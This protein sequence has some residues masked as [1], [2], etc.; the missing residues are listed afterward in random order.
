M[1]KTR[2]LLDFRIDWGYIYLYSRRHYHPQYIWDGELT[3]KDG[4]ILESY[5]L[6]Y[7]LAWYMPGLCPNE[8]KLP[9]PRW[10]SRTKRHIA[11]VRFV[12]EVTEDT[13]FTLSTQSGTFF[14]T[15]QQIQQDGRITFTV[16]PK[17][18]Q[19]QVIVTRTGY[20]W[21]RP[22]CP[23]GETRFMEADLP[24]PQHQWSRTPLAYLEPGKTV[25]VELSVPQ[26][27]ADYPE[28]LMHM[29]AMAVPAYALPEWPVKD[30][31]PM[32]LSCDGETILS[33]RYFFNHHDGQLQI[34]EDVWQR[35]SVSP[36]KHVI[37]LKNLHPELCLGI[38]RIGFTQR[39]FCHGQVSL[40]QWALVNE[41]VHGAVFAAWTDTI[42]VEG[43]GLQYQLACTPGWNE[44][45]ICPE[46]PG[47]LTLSTKN[48]SDS[49]EVYPIEE[50]AVPVKVGADMTQI[51]HDDTGTMDWLLE[52][53]HRTRLGNYVIFRSFTGPVADEL[54]YRWGDYCRRHGIY[55]AACT[56][57]SSGAFSKGAGEYQ[58]ACGIH[59]YTGLVYARDP[60]EP[61]LSQDMKQAAEKFQKY[62]RKEISAVR[63]SCPTVAF[64]DGSGGSRH[65]FIAGADF[66]RAETMVGHTMTL[67]SQA[68]P[69]AEA[70]GNGG[71]GVHIA[72]QH[73]RQPYMSTHLGEYFLCLMQPWIMGAELIY[74][75][76]CLFGMWSEERMT[77]DDL[78]VKGKRDMTRSFY[79]FVKTHPRK[80]RN[81][82]NIAFLEGRYAAPFNGF[83][84][85]VEQDPHYSVWGAFGNPDPTWGHCQP[86][87]CRQLLDVLMP[88]A[89]THPL[90]QKFNKRRFYFSGTPYGDFDCIPVE[91]DTDYWR[92]YR[93]LL[94]LGWNTMIP[95][96]YQKLK[97]FVSGGGILLTGIPQFSTHVGRGFLKDMQDLSLWNG[98]DLTQLCGIRVNGC[99][100]KYS[101]QWNCAGR[102]AILEPEL[103]AL[104]SDHPD[105]DGPSCLADITLDGAQVVAWDAFS[106]KP[107]LVKKP[108]GKGWVYTFTLWAYPGHEQFQRFC[109]AWIAELA[110]SAL[111]QTYLEDP[112]GEVFWTR[113][114]QD[115]STVLMVLNTDWTAPG[116]EKQVTLHTQTQQIPLSVREQTL[117]VVTIQDGAAKIQEYTL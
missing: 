105:E 77:W 65:S 31:I 113:W 6:D 11:G 111:P 86:E 80:G 40:P 83:I 56:D 100:S 44:F 98:G 25:E 54:M 90:R 55:A 91:A 23:E 68:R 63:Q 59:E 48:H 69:A 7:P 4:E 16:G 13:V 61:Y 92:S 35:F 29:T 78:L 14:F 50:E 60:E 41:A 30:H 28:T 62:L 17:Y 79:K 39:E 107:M 20:F 109:A 5:Q 8:T 104:P 71:W 115:E 85:D 10:E 43:G 94:N 74:E 87:K 84:C 82:R 21:F 52:Y 18:L 106:G 103:S 67:L 64:G 75:E 47:V 26:S 112:S 102:E 95:E 108:L 73:M 97:D 88:G 38:S 34:L 114:E 33:F 37:G 81:V 9:A 12:A 93:L 96:D 22:P 1:K 66:V 116:N 49:M 46:A 99:G 15:A 19:C 42:T 3:C 27:S 101:G 58:H 72:I 45:P 2:F 117:L 36:G 53:F 76:D 24:L 51:P 89:S 32:E 110:K 57:Y 70:L